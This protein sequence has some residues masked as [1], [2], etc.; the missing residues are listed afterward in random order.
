MALCEGLLQ[1]LEGQAMA[2]DF[3]R[4]HR[5][6]LEIGVLAAIEPAAM[7]Y[8]FPLVARAT[9]AEGAA[10]KITHADAHAWCQ[11]CL[12]EVS[13]RAHGQECPHCG[14]RRLRLQDGMQMMI[15]QVEVS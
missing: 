4:V 1:A 9:L 11:D 15:K 14:G 10:L 8:N 13:I 5:I 12:A 7:L 2:Q 3:T 6:W